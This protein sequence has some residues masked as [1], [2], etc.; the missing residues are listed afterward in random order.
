MST[1]WLF[2]IMGICLV[3][4]LFVVYNYIKIYHMEEGNER[5]VKM[6]GI[7]REGANV[8]IKKEFTTIA[9][10]IAVL[11]VLF[12]LFIEKFSGLTYILGATMS[13]I[14]C[15][16]GM[17]SATY[18]NVRTANK[19][20]ESLSIGETVK[21]ALKGGSISGLSVQALGLLGIV[22]IVL[23]SGI[24]GGARFSRSCR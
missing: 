6:S 2:V 20:K 12:T 23:I 19:A 7:I 21:V 13:S 16:V 8:F 3:A 10:V 15:I 17:K 9:I 4:L 14:V 24:G 1:P 5:M 11:A 22:L 18:A